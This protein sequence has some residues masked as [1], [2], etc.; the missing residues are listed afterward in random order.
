MFTVSLQ[1]DR[2]V[3]IGLS[4]LV[5]APFIYLFIYFYQF[6]LLVGHYFIPSLYPS[7][8]D[9]RLRM[10]PNFVEDLGGM[11]EAYIHKLLSPTY[12]KEFLIGLFSLQDLVKYYI[13]LGLCCSLNIC[14]P[15][16]SR[17]PPP[18]MLKT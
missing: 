18:F 14:V 10:Q 12:H 4:P 7:I 17:R 16:C 11:G 6:L 5:S 1:D 9:T 15:P 3:N 8:T 2:H 13:L